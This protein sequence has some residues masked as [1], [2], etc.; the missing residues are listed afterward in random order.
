MK[1][2]NREIELKNLKEIEVAS[3]NSSKMS[4]IYGKRRVGKTA[5]VKKGL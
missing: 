1:F 3:K 2:Y 5:L 4:I